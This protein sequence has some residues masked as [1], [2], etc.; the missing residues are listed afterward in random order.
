M[1]RAGSKKEYLKQA[2]AYFTWLC[3]L[4]S[5]YAPA[6][7]Q[8]DLCFTENDDRRRWTKTAYFVAGLT[9][10]G[11]AAGI[12]CLANSSGHHKHH[13]RYSGD[14]SIDNYRPYSYSSHSSYSSYSDHSSSYSDESRDHHHHHR[15]HHSGY[16]SSNPYSIFSENDV[17]SWSGGSDFHRA[18]RAFTRGK[19]HKGTVSRDAAGEDKALSGQF[20]GHA[21]AGQEGSLTAFV[22]LPDGTSHSLGNISGNG[23]FSYGPFYQKGTYTFGVSLDRGNGLPSQMK[24][25]SIQI[26]VDCSTVQR[27]EFTAPPHAPANYEPAPCCFELS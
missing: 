2:L 21:C 10:I 18:D 24:M 8:G 13:V 16:Y 19:M 11:I 3:V 25:G 9:V 5:A 14:S 6:Q 17:S 26:E 27:H 12:A 15:H 20:I 1:F 7:A 4:L 22:Q 23:S